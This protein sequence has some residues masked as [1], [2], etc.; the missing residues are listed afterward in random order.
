MLYTSYLSKLKDLPDEITKIIITRTLPKSL[1]FEKFENI[2]YIQSLSPS[3]ELLMD[4]KKNQNWDSYVNNFKKEMEEREDLKLE[5]NSLLNFLKDE[6]V[7]LICYEKD[8]RHCHRSLIGEWV[9]SHGIQWQEYDF[10]GNK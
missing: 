5:L 4:Y 10:D 3:L 8:Y 9:Q 6:E 7:V 1:N 2:Y